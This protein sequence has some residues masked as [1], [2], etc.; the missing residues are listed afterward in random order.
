MRKTTK[1]RRARTTI[2]PRRLVLRLLLIPFLSLV[3]LLT[4]TVKLQPRA[5]RKP[6][7]YAVI[8]GTVWGPDDRPVP[9]VRLKLRRA[10]EKK[11]RWETYSDRRGEFE[12]RLPVGPETYIV[13]AD[14]KGYK[15]PEHKPL[16]AGTEVSVRIEQN[17]RADIGVHLK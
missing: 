16:K 4:S 9:G 14:L 11:A 2:T 13:W 1:K 8:F 12:F 15:S 10:G 3:F 6:A 5:V 17:E 7:H